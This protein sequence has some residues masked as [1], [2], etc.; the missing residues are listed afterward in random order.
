[1]LCLLLGSAAIGVAAPP[2]SPPPVEIADGVIVSGV[3]VGRLTSEQARARM[4]AAISRPLVFRF[5]KRT[6]KATPD[7]LEARFAVDDAVTKA[8][9]AAPGERIAVESRLPRARVARYVAYLARTFERRPRNSRLVGLVGGRPLVTRSRTGVAVRRQAMEE[10]ISNALTAGS[11]R[12]IRLAV[13]EV[14][15]YLTR[16]DFGS[17]I[18]INRGTKTLQLFRGAQPV[19]KFRVATGTASYPTPSG[20]FRIVDKQRYPWWYPPPSD[21]A[22][23]LKPVPPGPGNPLGTRWMGLSGGNVGIHGTPD[24]ASVGYS[25][26]HG[27]IRMYISEATWL[28]DHVSV[29]TPVFIT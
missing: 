2:A 22:R 4:R 20:T 18:V 10:A 16:A 5:G 6:W 14:R 28:F 17:I 3:A 21:W 13:R 7:Q 24:A 26:S 15:P 9:L 11:R 23:G 12:P 1:V 27:C 19:K 29:G 8:L 25:A